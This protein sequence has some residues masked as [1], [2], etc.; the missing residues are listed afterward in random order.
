MVPAAV[1]TPRGIP[2]WVR[3]GTAMAGTCRNASPNL[4]PAL[5]PAL[6]TQDHS[7]PGNQILHPLGYES[8]RLISPSWSANAAFFGSYCARSL[9]QPVWSCFLLPPPQNHWDPAQLVSRYR[10]GNG[11]DPANTQP[12]G[13]SKNRQKWPFFSC[14]IFLLC[15][16]LLPQ[17][18]CPPP[19]VSAL[20]SVALQTDMVR[21]GVECSL[22]RAGQHSW[23]VQHARGN[24]SCSQLPPPSGKRG[25]HLHEHLSCSLSPPAITYPL[26]ALATSLLL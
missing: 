9:L 15:H 19:Q 14:R 16:Q 4:R 5:A 17:D 8:G 23:S 26:L 1:V 21:S 12:H 22:S 7:Q 11:A 6:P 2:P 25:C 3:Q 24:L 13:A 10:T 20:R 18:A